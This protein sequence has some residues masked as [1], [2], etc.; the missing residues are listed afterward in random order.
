MKILILLGIVILVNF[1]VSIYV[2]SEDNNSR[3]AYFFRYLFKAT[4]IDDP[5]IM[6]HF[7]VYRSRKTY[8]NS[9]ISSYLYE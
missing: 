1:A 8:F 3:N 9:L 4:F 7:S 2:F 5:C 6:K